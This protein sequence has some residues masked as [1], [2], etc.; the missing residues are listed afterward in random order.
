M[1][2]MNRKKN[3][4]KLCESKLDDYKL[5]LFEKILK[6]FGKKPKKEKYLELLRD[7]LSKN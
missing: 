6:S 1:H 3:I 7:E 5:D 2:R 4:E